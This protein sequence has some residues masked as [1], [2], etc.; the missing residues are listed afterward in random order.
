MNP[1]RQLVWT[2]LLVAAATAAAPAGATTRCDMLL[3]AQGWVDAQVP[4]SQDEADCHHDPLR[5]DNSYRPD[6]SGYVSATWFLDPPGLDTGTFNEMGVCHEINSSELLPGDALLIRTSSHHHI[7]LFKAWSQNAGNIWAYEEYNYGEVAS[8][9]EHDLSSMLDTGYKPIRYNDVEPCE[10]VP[11]PKVLLSIDVII[12]DIPG[13]PR[14]FAPPDKI[15]DMFVA[16]QTV[17]HLTVTNDDAS[18]AR[19]ENPTAV[20]ELA[21]PHLAIR[22]WHIYDN[23]HNCGTPW[24][25]NDSDSDPANPPHADPPSTFTL[26]LHGMAAGESKRVD[27]LVQGMSPSDLTHPELRFF[28]KHVDDFYEKASWDGTP[29][30]VDGYQTFN[31]GD[32]KVLV[33]ADV[34]DT[35]NESE[36]ESEAGP[37]PDAAGAD[38]HADAPSNASP[39]ADTNGWPLGP[40]DSSGCG[41]AVPR[42]PTSSALFVAAACLAWLLRRRR[43]VA[44]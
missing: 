34:W 6:C 19:A 28:I 29:N 36:Q 31:H 32:L 43:S 25:V 37:P 39:D 11:P 24:C 23:H 9:R 22:E 10:P 42:R 12:D 41:C 16:Q 15:Y 1:S 40:D 33:R 18:T 5:N 14:D 2:G 26:A 27:L 4:Y 44:K 35:P 20:V 13:Q 8:I 7:M 30:N 17:V 38:A 21:S 3:D